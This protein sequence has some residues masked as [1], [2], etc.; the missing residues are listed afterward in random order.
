LPQIERTQLPG[1]SAVV[2][3]ADSPALLAKIQD[4]A[5]VLARLDLVFNDS[6]DDFGLVRAP[7]DAD[8]RKIIEFVESHRESAPN[9]VF[10][11]QVGVGRSLA[12]YAAITEIYG[13][14]PS[15]A[16]ARGTHNRVLHRKILGVAGRAP[17]A[18]PLVSLIVRVKYAPDRMTAFMLSMRRQRYDN[19]QL[20]FVTDGRN[21]AAR[22]LAEDAADPRIKVV[23]TEKALGRWGHPHRQAGIDASTGGLIGL[24]ND[25]NYYVPGYLEQMVNAIENE[26]A[27][28]AMCSMLHSYWGWQ[29]VEAGHDLGSWI[30]RR[31]LI[32]RTPWTGDYFFY[33]A[34]YLAL[35]KKNASRIAIVNRPLFI[36]N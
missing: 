25:D 23:E 2:C 5:N 10:Q 28:I 33:D 29:Q 20:V 34:D 1:P 35:L 30:A 26:K 7:G 24:S 8:A 18:E 21:A 16:L 17:R 9:I 15:A 22:K 32:S 27:D 12:A 19:W 3:M 11:C 13:G 6:G 36:H 4:S 31:E 14:D